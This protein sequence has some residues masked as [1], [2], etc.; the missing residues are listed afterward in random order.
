MSKFNFDDNVFCISFEGSNNLLPDK[1]QP[2]I[3]GKTYIGTV[4]GITEICKRILF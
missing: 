4:E 1:Y 2:T 3:L